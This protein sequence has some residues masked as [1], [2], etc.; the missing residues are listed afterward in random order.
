MKRLILVNDS[1]DFIYLRTDAPKEVIEKAI[2]L[3]NLGE[4]SLLK[5]LN[6]YSH[7][8]IADSEYGDKP[9]NLKPLEIY[10][11]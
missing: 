1:F 5:Y 2:E 4:G 8:V 11:K 10:R 3:E 6:G 9:E 7:E